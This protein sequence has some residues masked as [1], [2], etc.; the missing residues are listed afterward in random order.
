MGIDAGTSGIKALVMDAAG[1]IMGVG[2]CEC[3][4]ITPKPNWVEQNPLDWWE[5]CSKE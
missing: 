5:A 1:K 4:L 3:D 2:Y